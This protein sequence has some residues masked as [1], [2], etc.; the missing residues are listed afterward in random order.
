MVFGDDDQSIYQKMRFANPG[1]VK[2]F[3]EMYS[4]TERYPLSI[5]WRCGSSILDA[6]WKLIN[7]NKCKMPDRMPKDK[8]ISNPKRGEGYIEIKSFKSEKEEITELLKELKKELNNKNGLKEILILFQIR[9]IGEHYVKKM[10]QRGYC[11]HD[12]KK[13][14]TFIRQSR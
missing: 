10:I 14:A 13:C 4:G 6:A 8:P 5:C 9:D 2:N 11:E 12:C 3:T 7:V 1:G